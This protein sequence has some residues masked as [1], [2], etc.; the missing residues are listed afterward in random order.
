MHPNFRLLATIALLLSAEY[1]AGAEPP[2]DQSVTKELGTVRSSIRADEEVVFYRTCGS[3]DEKHGTWRLPIHGIVYEP[4]E[5]SWR[6][7]AVAVSVRKTLGL[8][9]DGVKSEFLDRRLR[10]FLVDNE[11]GKEIFVRIGDRAYAAGTSEANGHFQATLLLA[12]DDVKQLVETDKDG[13]W[14][15]FEA[16]MPRSDERRFQGRVQLIEPAGL[17][18]ISDI[19][20]TIKHSAVGDR[21]ALLANT[22][23]RKFQPVAG[24][25]GLFGRSAEQGMAFHYVSG[26]PWQLYLPL[27]EFLED[28]GFPKGSMHLKRFR[29]KVRS[30]ATVLVSQEA[31]K[32]PAI[33]AILAAYPQRRFILVGD[34][35]EQDPEIYAKVARKH[36]GQVVGLFI[37]NVTGEAGDGPRFTAVREGLGDVRFELFEEPE[38]LSEVVREIRSSGGQGSGPRAGR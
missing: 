29:L 2:E 22:F 14:L 32:L 10:L 28:E 13:R 5:D 15:P 21:K 27:A 4:E 31:H 30:M 26:S 23:L 1:G 11:G 16:V 36:A 35:G 24:M 33:E 25:P 3:Y 38:S 12:D 37:R 18:I 6:R 20:D 8:E 34:S 7:G 9:A 17:S 19:D